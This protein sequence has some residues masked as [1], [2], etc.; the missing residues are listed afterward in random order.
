MKTSKSVKYILVGI[1]LLVLSNCLYAATPQEIA[2]AL[3][4]ARRDL[5]I[6][7]AMEERITS[8]LTKLKNSGIESEGIMKDY[9]YYLS[10]V[11]AMVAENRK[12]VAE[13]AALNA[14]YDVRKASDR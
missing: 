7:I 5:H 3:A 10:L 14:M 6:S 11:K 2:S 9:E 1:L 13:M 12:L 8:K 4:A